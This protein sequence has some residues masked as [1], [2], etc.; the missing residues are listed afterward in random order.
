M[1]K[2]RCMSVRN[3]GGIETGV[4]TSSG[5]S[6]ERTLFTHLNTIFNFKLDTF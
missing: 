5:A 6:Y 1:A 3:E 2:L 4:K